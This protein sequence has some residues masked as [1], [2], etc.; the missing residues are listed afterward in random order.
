MRFFTKN[1]HQ[2]SIIVL[3]MAAIVVGVWPWRAL[4]ANLL[5][6]NG[7]NNPFSA[8]AGR[9]WNGQNEHIAAGWTPFY[10]NAST[11]PGS[12]NASKLHWMSSAQFGATFGG[13]DYHIEGDA[14][15]NMWSSYEF[16]AGVYQQVS[17]TQG[18]AYQFD[19]AM[20]TYWRGPGY[21]DSNGKMVKQIG[22]DPYGGTDPTSSNI[23][24]SQTDSNDKAW[25]RLYAAAT[26][27]ANTITVFAK[28]YAPENTSFNH[29]DLD[30][31]Y[32]EDAHVQQINS[33]P[34]TSLNASAGGVTVNANWSGSAASGWTLKGYEV[35]YKDQAGSTWTTLQNKNGLNTSGSF[36]GQAGHTYTIQARTWQ[37]NGTVDLPGAWVETNVSVNEV[38]LGRVLSYQGGGLDGVTVSIS[39]TV[40]STVSANG[41][42]YALSG[43]G[44]GTFTITAGNYNGLAAPP[45]ASVTVPANGSVTLD[46]VLRPTG[47]G[48]ALTNNDFE[49]DLSGWNVS[50]GLTAAIS[51]TAKHSGQNGLAI[52]NSS[53]VS[54]TNSVA[55]MPNPLLSFWYKSD[56]VFSV[57]LLGEPANAAPIQAQA[58]SPISTKLLNPVTSWTYVTLDMGLSGAYTGTVGVNFTTSSAANIAIDEVSLA[59]GPTNK[60]F[61]PLIIK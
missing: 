58:V 59:A 13:L 8:I 61:L 27:Q 45:P 41:G 11:Y 4:A 48:Q 3:G 60:L 36:T 56:T 14:A 5:A 20:V 35:R 9:S 2:L 16:D 50:N 46:I 23:V 33:P 53:Q 47:A 1:R 6:N 17:A 44:P 34:S 21:P 26:A 15:Q 18:S 54:Q 38:V 39:G 52:T 12:G 25:I 19:I 32:F 24:W 37:T 10:I 55:A 51:S 57:D 49:T 40:T 42:N 43:G 30:M 22:I 31:V 7:F 29:T 28:V